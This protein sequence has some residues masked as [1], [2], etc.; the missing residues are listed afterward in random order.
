MFFWNS[1]PFSMIQRKDL[2]EKGMATHSSILASPTH[3]KD[4]RG[5]SKSP[6]FLRQPC[7][8]D[9]QKRPSGKP[10]LWFLPSVNKT[11]SHIVSMKPYGSLDSP[12]PFNFNRVTISPRPYWGGIGGGRVEA[13]WGVTMRH[14]FASKADWCQWKPSGKPLLLVGKPLSLLPSEMRNGNE[15]S[16]F[17]ECHWGAY[18]EPEL[19]PPSRDNRTLSLLGYN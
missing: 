6:S 12:Q 19:P 9:S 8:W 7:C 17:P 16:L 15:A 1:L 13:M 18:E 5:S 3:P 14:L 10:G 4:F 11:S 2:L